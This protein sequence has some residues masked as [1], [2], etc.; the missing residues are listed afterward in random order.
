M[1]LITTKYRGKVAENCH[2]ANAVAVDASGDVIFS[3]GEE[4]FPAFMNQIADPLR[5]VTMLEEKVDKEFAL[6][7]EDLALMTSL[8]KGED[9]FTQ[10]I[11]KLLRKMDMSPSDL[12]CPEQKPEDNS[13]YERLII[14][15]K[16]PTHLHNSS[17]G[18]HTGMLAL[19]K[20]IEDST[21]SYNSF[22]HPVQTKYLETMKKYAD[23]DKIYREVDDNGIPSFS[24]SLKDISK[25]YS[26]FIKRDDEY[27]QRVTDILTKQN[28]NVYS[29]STFNFDFTKILNGNGIARSNKNGLQLVGVKTKGGNYVGIAVKVLSGDEEAA[30]S[31]VLEML[32]HLKMMENTKLKKLKKYHKPQ[33]KDRSGNT[34]LKMKTE[35]TT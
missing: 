16:R 26:N 15:G 13:S 5:T 22:N 17:S 27:L 32:R 3:A 18:V 24:L 11:E 9:K 23:T 14:Q 35:I 21:G 2:V 19:E 25:I 12:L 34:L 29:T 10:K 33:Q 8:H 28:E 4:N 30:A 31:M 7:D 20:K 6:S 1:K